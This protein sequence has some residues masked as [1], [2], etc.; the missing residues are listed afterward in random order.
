MCLQV[1]PTELPQTVAGFH[2]LVGAAATATA[3]A[4]FIGH[5]P[6]VSEGVFRVAVIV[7]QHFFLWIVR[8]SHCL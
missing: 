7:H 2:S 5:A 8:C 6:E 1:G 3:F 4:E